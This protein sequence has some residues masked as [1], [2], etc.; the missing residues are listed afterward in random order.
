MS[1]N[2]SHRFRGRVLR[3]EVLWSLISTNS[4]SK[5][6]RMNQ[7]HIDIV[8]VRGA[9]RSDA[10]TT[11]DILLRIASPEVQTQVL[12]P[13]LNLGLVLDR[14]GSMAAENKMGY[15]KEAAVFAVQQL[16]PTDRV[17]VTI[18]DDVVETIVPNEPAVHKERIV[19]RIQRVG[20]RNSTALHAGWTEG[21]KQVR[22][23]LIAGGL[24]R[25]LL[26]SDGLANVGVTN[27]D[28][29]ATDV[30]Q[31]AQ[32]GVSTTTIG[33]GDDY[34]EDLMEAMARSGEGNY[35]YVESP[36][37]LPEMFQAE[38]RE[39]M[40]TIG[41]SVRLGIEP[42]EGTTVAEVLNDLDRL[43]G[44]YL[45][46]P[47]LVSGMTLFVLI[48]LTVAPAAGE[49]EVC[50]FRLAWNAPKQALPQELTAS[51]C[52]PAVDAAVWESL[53]EN[54]EVRERVALLLIARCKKAAARCSELGDNE[55]AAQ[56]LAEARKILA[57]APPTEEMRREE[58]A[59][60]EI[61]EYLKEGA[62]LK[63]RKRSKSQ[64]Y[65][66]QRSKPFHHF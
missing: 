64:A 15:A 24:N 20:S 56:H 58:E 22:Q 9:L 3:G 43:P 19:D 29:I 31:L 60:A 54:L 27:S 18:F 40:D 6:T 30:N 8:P 52:L 1:A 2:A 49:R 21:G 57:S 50:R 51:L 11:L 13:A 62:D 61:E 10:D 25:V 33:V 46:L 17:S 5:E 48:R 66:A 23:N 63:L 4:V 53:A 32:E 55:G 34:N 45:K 39:L 36:R 42:R 59:L 12:R 26:L 47:N 41:E 44:G 35:Y 65:L 14:S 37:Q 38:L 7:P 28:A 16:L